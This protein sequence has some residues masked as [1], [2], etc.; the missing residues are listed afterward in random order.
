MA[1]KNETRTVCYFKNECRNCLNTIKFP[2]LSDFTYGE[3]IYQTKDGKD[4][5]IAQLPDNEI[6]DF[7]TEFLKNDLELKYKTLIINIFALTDR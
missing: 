4:F 7:I 5:C 1:L 2:I 6:F 3:L